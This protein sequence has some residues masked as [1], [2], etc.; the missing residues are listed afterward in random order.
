[1]I[2]WVVMKRFL[3]LTMM[4]AL[5]TG[6]FWPL[7]SSAL[8]ITSNAIIKSINN[9]R[10]QA[11]LPTLRRDVRLETAARIR[12]NIIIRQATINHGGRTTKATVVIRQ[13]GYHARRSGELLAAD[14]RTAQDTVAAW[15]YSPNH[16]YILYDRRFKD[17]GVAITR[18]HR[19]QSFGIVVVVILGQRSGL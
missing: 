1:M 13:V 2:P 11:G 12:S 6:L 5:G 7:S 3:W 14:F 19:G 18:N 16:R 15:E 10:R 9:T 8:S 17:I 4:I